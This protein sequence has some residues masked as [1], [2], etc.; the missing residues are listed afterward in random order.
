ML[1]KHI[2]IITSNKWQSRTFNYLLKG[3]LLDQYKLK[4]INKS[5]QNKYYID[6]SM[7]TYA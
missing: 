3:Q 2:Y 5:I 6:L 7:Y 1:Q 4:I